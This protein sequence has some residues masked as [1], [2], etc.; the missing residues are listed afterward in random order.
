MRG[1]TMTLEKQVRTLLEKHARK[2]GK[3][4]IL[5]IVQVGDE[6]LRQNAPV[7]KGELKRKTLDNLIDAMRETMYYAPGVG[8]AA[9]QIGLSLPIAVICD[10]VDEDDEEIA[11][12]PREFSNV[13][14]KVI[15]NPSYKACDREMREFY[16]GCLSFDGFSAKRKRHRKVRFVYEDTEGERHSEILTGWA[17]RIVQ[18]ETDH[19]K[20]ELYIDR[21]DIKSLVNVK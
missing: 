15:I 2:D 8:L 17:A 3:P 20:G 19:L 12:D 6:V 14:F 18:H 5:P 7:Y 10:T 11:D 21:A 13:D 16:E 9:P 1:T 4:T